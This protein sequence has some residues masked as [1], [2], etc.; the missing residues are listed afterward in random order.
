MSTLSYHLE[1]AR[2]HY[3]AFLALEGTLNI[4]YHRR[5]LLVKALNREKTKTGAAQLTGLTERTVHR[6]IDDFDILFDPRTE[7][8]Y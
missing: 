4:D 2:A 7:T 5:L 3:Q 8:Y 6:L 1:K